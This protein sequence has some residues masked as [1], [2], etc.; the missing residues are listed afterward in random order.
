MKK[1]VSF[2]INLIHAHCE[3]F[4][5]YEEKITSNPYSLLFINIFLYHQIVKKIL[6]NGTIFHDMTTLQFKYNS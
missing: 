6:F 4:R 2:I 3:K 1:Q 5:K